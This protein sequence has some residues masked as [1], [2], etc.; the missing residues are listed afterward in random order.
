MYQNKTFPSLPKA[1][2]QRVKTIKQA[3][4]AILG[5]GGRDIHKRP[6]K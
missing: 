5:G 6:G 1:G 3:F 2:P 4:L